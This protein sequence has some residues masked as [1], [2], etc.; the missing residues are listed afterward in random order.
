MLLEEERGQ[1][2]KSWQHGVSALEEQQQQLLDAQRSA[3]Q[4]LS[5]TDTC[6]FIHRYNRTKDILSVKS[7]C[8]NN[9]DSEL[10]YKAFILINCELGS[11]DCVD[12][13]MCHTYSMSLEIVSQSLY[14]DMSVH[15]CG[16]K[17]RNLLCSL[18][19]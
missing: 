18:G 17:V 19:S 8:E 9:K 7:T 14:K 16:N 12:Y 4:A 3:T 15:V 1:R 13:N 11:K 6:V 5:E 2:R 10:N